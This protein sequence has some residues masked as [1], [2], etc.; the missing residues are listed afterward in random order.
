MSLAVVGLSHHTAPVDVRER[1][2]FSP[3]QAEKALVHITASDAV[4][5]AVILSTCNRTELYYAEP[6]AEDAPP[7]ER[8]AAVEGS[9][10]SAVEILA[11]RAGTTPDGL[12]QYLYHHRGR[13]VAQHLFRVVSSLDSM[14][15]GEAQIQG[16]VKSAYELA[17]SLQSPVTGPVLSRLFQTALNV[18]GRVR[19]ETALGMGAASVPAAAVEL[20]RK[21]FGSLKGRHA[22]VLG[23]GEMS[24]LALEAL[25]GEGVEGV[26]VANRS[27]TR[28][29][30]QVAALVPE[31]DII[32]T[33]TSAPHA[34]LTRQ[35]M[36]QALKAGR[37]HPLLILDIALPRDVEPAVGELDNVFLY[38]IDDLTQI[39][40]RNLEKRKTELPRAERIVQTAVEDYWAWYTS[41]E[42]VPLI[43]A[44]R[45]QA[46]S[47]RRVEV[48][49]ALRKLE[50]LA[51]E[52]REAVEVLTKQILNKVLHKPTVRL[53]E[54]ASNGRGP[55][56][57]EAARYL[58]Q[59]DDPAEISD[60]PNKDDNGE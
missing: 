39:V 45:G 38:D 40:D 32:A 36:G 37:A 53:R 41:L 44:L 57:V 26:V 3:T 43:R 1:L 54:A 49:K 6:G 47:Y 59:I 60:E 15:L 28:A 52:D 14:I 19:N 25:K 22:L 56:L 48:E 50:H 30:D 20:G 55:T 10:A 12:G 4:G 46:E 2:V 31:T 27:M 42:V 51:P 29:H 17:A 8:A 24:E 18:G 9:R 58:F 23:A 13:E 7:R 34:V 35:L 5:E 11:E 16:Q 21:I 33:A